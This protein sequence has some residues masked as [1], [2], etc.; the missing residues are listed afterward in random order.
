MP[1]DVQVEHCSM[2]SSTKLKATENQ[3]ESNVHGNEHCYEIEVHSEIHN[4]VHSMVR[5]NPSSVIRFKIH[6]I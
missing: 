3:S 5:M 4:E 2:N 6:S 1:N